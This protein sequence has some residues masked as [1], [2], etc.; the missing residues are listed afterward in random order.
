MLSWWMS[1]EPVW[2]VPRLTF[3]SSSTAMASS[4]SGFETWAFAHARA[5][6]STGTTMMN[7]STN[8]RVVNTIVSCSLYRISELENPS[9]AMA[10]TADT[11]KIMLN[12]LEAIFVE[13]F[14]APCRCCTVRTAA[15]A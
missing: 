2:S 10:R 1:S 5:V 15:D 7:I 9:D 14:F 4:M 8:M 12:S 11:I 13:R 6:S 3:A